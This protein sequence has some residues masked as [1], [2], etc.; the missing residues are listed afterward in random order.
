MKRIV[1]TTLL[2]TVL[3]LSGC[4]NSILLTLGKDPDFKKTLDHTKKQQ[5]KENNQTVAIFRATYLNPIYPDRYDEEQQHFFIGIHIE[6]DLPQPKAGIRNPH[7]RL[8]MNDLNASR[9][10]EIKEDDPLYKSMPLVE[11]WTRYYVV[12]FDDNSSKKLNLLYK[13]DTNESLKFS[14]PRYIK[15][16]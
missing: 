8:S 6:D 14:F 16:E 3:L 2:G 4:G 12:T 10:D 5:F 15:P 11:R 13:K 7:Y 9:Y 1:T